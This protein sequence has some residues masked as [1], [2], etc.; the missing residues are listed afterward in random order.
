MR[1]PELLVQSDRATVFHDHLEPDPLDA[2]RARV[3]VE[4]LHQ[5]AAGSAPPLR[6][7][8][9]DAA[10]PGVGAAEPEVREAHALAVTNGDHRRGAVEVA[11][12]GERAHGGRID[13]E[14]HEVPLVRRGE[15]R[16][17]L[18]VG[19]IRGRLQLD[20]RH[21]R[22]LEE[23]EPAPAARCLRQARGR[24]VSDGSRTPSHPT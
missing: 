13:R 12:L 3:L 5:P 4:S 11:R 16:R 6:G 20:V 9:A 15:D 18:L 1:V 23:D 17:E 10:D 14:R 2:V 21:G 24:V 22:S 7:D 8:D 19:E